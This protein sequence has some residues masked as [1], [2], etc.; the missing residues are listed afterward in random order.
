MT[1][2]LALPPARSHITPRLHR[3]LRGTFAFALAA[4]LLGALAVRSGALID[5]ARFARPDDARVVTDRHGEVLRLVRVDGIDRRWVSLAQMSPHLI[6]AVLA[7]EDADFHAH[8]GVDGRAVLHAVARAVAPGRRWSGASTITQQLVKRVYGRSGPWSK[9]VE[10]LRAV[11]L[12]R[13]LSKDEIL[14]QYLNRLPFGDGIE[15]V[16]RACESYFGHDV[17]TVTVAEAALLAGIPQAPSATEP[18]RHR[19][20][21]LARRAYVL[22]RM[23]AVGAITPAQWTE[24]R[25]EAL[26]VVPIAAHPW[27]APRAVDAA[28]DRVRRGEIANA[29]TIRTSLDASLQRDAESVLRAAVERMAS[30]GARNGAAV[31]LANATGEVLAYVGAARPEG[32]GG[33]LDLARARRQPGSSLKPFV[34]ELL[35]ERGGTAA[36]V[37]DDIAVPLRGARGATFEARDY[38]GRE[39]GP[40]RARVALSASLNLAALDAASRVG[41]E[42]L[43]ARLRALGLHDLDDASHYGAAVVLGGADVSALELARAWTALARGGTLVPLSFA[44]CD[45]RPGVRVMTAD[46]A[47]LTWDVLSDSAARADAFGR[48][49][50][51]LTGGLPFALKTGTSSNWRD[52]WATVATRDF[53]VTVWLGDPDGAAMREVS[54]FEAAAPAAARIL[55]RAMRQPSLVAMPV[56]DAANLVDAPVCAHSGLRPGPRC[57]HVIRERFARDA[58]PTATCEAHDEHGRPRVPARFAAWAARQTAGTVTVATSQPAR[59]DDALTIAEPRE[60]A[61]WMLDTTREAPEITL[62]AHGADAWAHDLVWEV[63]GVRLAGDRWRATVGEHRVVAVRGA[64]RSAARTVVVESAGPASAH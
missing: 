24:A 49:L 34:Y 20:R 14:E 1:T 63:D 16:A 26:S 29:P 31:V 35:F 9:P 33:A 44:P 48:D 60:G 23:R 22:D 36:T 10:M 46:A 39:R 19:T 21:A 18:R 28:L 40:V 6:A 59:N 54:G 41:S 56:V 12:E 55:A 25:N 64:R 2:A 51:D 38:D 37:L 50:R 58:L 52:A 4:L 8:G 45:R 57:T 62:R 53:T 17:S 3:A 7:A 43:V 42:R 32:P 5:R 27:L 13:V 15:G 61:R 47:A 11:A 30:R